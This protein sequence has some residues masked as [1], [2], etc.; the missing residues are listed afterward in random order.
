MTRRS[1]AAVW[2]PVGL[3]LAACAPHRLELPTGAGEPFPEYAQALQG[4]TADC[5]GVRTFS[6]ELSIAGRAG[7]E[8]LRGR[9]AAGLAE[10]ARA[11]LEGI[12]PFGPPAFILVADGSSATLFLPRD[13]RVL[14][15]ASPAGI[16]DALVGLD[17]GAADLRAILAGC[18]ATDLQPASGRSYAG[19]WGRIEL[20]GGGTVFVQRDGRQ[21]WRVR[22]GL[23]PPLRIEYERAPGATT[24]DAVR[25]LTIGE[26]GSGTDL[27]IGLSQVETNVTLAP[28][29]F[30]IKVPPDA[31][32]LT[33]AE[34]RQAGPIGPRK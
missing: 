11:R 19:G 27:R 10:P 23:R 18:V 16:L 30:S 33:L 24:L 31:A 5:R 7:H 3:L 28:A 15:A 4:A 17:L 21:P 14:A 1:A 20:T 8:K 22:A 9:V 32:P 25:L 34:L 2:L 13:N 29:V 6:A 26:A 12:A